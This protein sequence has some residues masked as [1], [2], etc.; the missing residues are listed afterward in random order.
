MRLLTFKGFS[1]FNFC[2][3]RGGPARQTAVGPEPLGAAGP[4]HGVRKNY[5]KLIKMIC[6]G[7]Q[8]PFVLGTLPILG[9]KVRDDETTER[10][11][12]PNLGMMGKIL[13]MMEPF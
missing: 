7:V 13:G 10:P 2:G 6:P 5:E 3:R 1:C 9:L 11:S 8:V 4:R 12:S